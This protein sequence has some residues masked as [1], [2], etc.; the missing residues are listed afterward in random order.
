MIRIEVDKFLGDVP[1]EDHDHSDHGESNVPMNPCP[2]GAQRS[3]NA[4][5]TESFES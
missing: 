4:P 5:G 2:D 1:D 3:F